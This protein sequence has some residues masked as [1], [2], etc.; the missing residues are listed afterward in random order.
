[1]LGKQSKFVG[2]TSLPKGLNFKHQLY[3]I[4]SLHLGSN[5]QRNALPY[6]VFPTLKF[7]YKVTAGGKPKV[8]LKKECGYNAD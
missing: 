5:L 2:K 1:M 6:K 4:K 7:E 3:K 8:T